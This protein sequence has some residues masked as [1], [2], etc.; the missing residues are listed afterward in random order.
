MR[1]TSQVRVGR[2][3]RDFAYYTD[4]N[5]CEINYSHTNAGNITK[6]ASGDSS[7][8]LHL[9]RYEEKYGVLPDGFF[10]KARCGNQGCCNPDHYNARRVG[11]DH[12]PIKRSKQLTKLTVAQIRE[13][14]VSTEPGSILAKR[15]GVTDMNISNIQLRKVFKKHTADLPRRVS[16][17]LRPEQVL[18][19]FHSAETYEM[20][21]TLYGVTRETIG[22]IKSGSRHKELLGDLVA[23]KKAEKARAKAE[24]AASKKRTRKPADVDYRLKD[25]LAKLS[26]KKAP[27]F[28]ISP[29]TIEA[30]ALSE[31]SDDK[32]VK[33]FGIPPSVVRG[34]REGHLYQDVLQK[35]DS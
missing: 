30:I 16:N 25:A 26:S 3:Q 4:E 23:A 17:S 21:A 14:M 32:V 35:M 24:E 18:E 2:P 12:S 5:G 6:I 9:I 11:E 20:L 10:L 31:E 34:I 28:T 7:R 33:A 15:Y 19:I 29:A 13:I 22:R 27:G 8:A 1:T